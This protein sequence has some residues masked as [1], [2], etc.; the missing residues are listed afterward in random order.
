LLIWFRCPLIFAD[1]GWIFIDF[2][3][4]GVDV[5]WYFV[6]WVRFSLIFYDLG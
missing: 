2:L 3:W 1:L 4:F 6:R 5:H